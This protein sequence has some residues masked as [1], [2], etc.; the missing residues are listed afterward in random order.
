MAAAI[1]AALLLAAGILYGFIQARQSLK[2]KNVATNPS[3]AGS[4]R[5]AGGPNA[6]EPKAAEKVQVVPPPAAA[7]TSGPPLVTGEPG[8]SQP[9]LEE[10]LVTIQNSTFT[11]AV[12]TVKKGA[13]VMWV[14]R[15]DERHNVIADD[16]A[17]DG[18]N[19]PVLQRNQAY[20]FVFNTAG[21]FAYH[22][23]PHPHM[24]ARVVVAE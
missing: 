20:V 5:P 3:A 12:L 21:E 9:A 4:T 22:C 2:D 10:H 8:Q 24:Q 7:P 16:F 14:N 15:D 1:A 6:E 23:G 11:P 17:P 18:L 19:G 13:K